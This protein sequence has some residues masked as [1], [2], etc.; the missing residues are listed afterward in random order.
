MD[1]SSGASSVAEDPYGSCEYAVQLGQA[2]AADAIAQG[3]P[4]VQLSAEQLLAV[5]SS[6][7]AGLL[8]AA[9][10]VDSP[11]RVGGTGTTSAFCIARSSRPPRSQPY[12]PAEGAEAAAVSAAGAAANAVAVALGLLGDGAA[13]TGFDVSGVKI[14]QAS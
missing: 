1:M 5:Q 13:V 10:M 6:Y 7:V 3:R 2:L 12:V 14:E 11:L 8:S 4:L 9:Q